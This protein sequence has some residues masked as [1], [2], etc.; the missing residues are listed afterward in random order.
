MKAH[1]FW[2]DLRNELVRLVHPALFTRPG[3]AIWVTALEW[4][5]FHTEIFQASVFAG[6]EPFTHSIVSATIS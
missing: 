4:S 3:T 1:R 6:D 2:T 5:L